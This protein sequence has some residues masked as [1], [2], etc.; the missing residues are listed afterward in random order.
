MEQ[1]SVHAQVLHSIEEHH[2]TNVETNVV[3]ATARK[4]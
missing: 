2:I 1:R 3:Y 4:S